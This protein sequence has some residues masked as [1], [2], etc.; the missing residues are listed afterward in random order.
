MILIPLHYQSTSHILH[1]FDIVCH[2]LYLLFFLVN[3]GVEKLSGVT[4]GLGS[5]VLGVSWDMDT[6]DTFL[7]A[8]GKSSVDG[9]EDVEEDRFSD[10]VL[11]MFLP[12][13]LVW[14]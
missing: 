12:A 3:T 8:S 2:I 7:M 4:S 9:C 14:K 1:F 13:S 10:I 5:G 11:S 6:V